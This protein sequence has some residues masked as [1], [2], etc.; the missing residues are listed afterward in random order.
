[1]RRRGSEAYSSGGSYSLTPA[2]TLWDIRL[3]A[4]YELVQL[5]ESSSIRVALGPMLQSWSGEAIVDT[6]TNLGGAAAV[7]LVA[8]ISRKFGLLVSGSL[9]VAS[10]PFSQEILDAF[11]DGRARSG[12]DA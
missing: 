8:P 2:M 5:G 6:R 7:T 10:S 1:M 3:L 12:L 4:S 11:G 9:G